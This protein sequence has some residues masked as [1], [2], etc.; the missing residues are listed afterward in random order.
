MTENVKKVLND[1]K[2]NPYKVRMGAGKLA[3]RYKV[4]PDDVNEARRLYHSSNKKVKVLILDIE[5]SPM[6]AWVWRRWKEN[7]YLDQTI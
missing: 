4:S 7:I 5:T 6:K 2:V 1:F 3:N